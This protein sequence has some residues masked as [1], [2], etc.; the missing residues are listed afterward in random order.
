[1]KIRGRRDA[2][3]RGSEEKTMGPLRISWRTENGRLT[4][5]WADVKA[6]EPEP[7]GFVNRVDRTGRQPEPNREHA[8]SVV[9]MLRLLLSMHGGLIK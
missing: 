9:R 3:K 1:L 8:V 2:V 7:C 4:S 6:E 5:R